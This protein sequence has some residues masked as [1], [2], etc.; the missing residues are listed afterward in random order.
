VI[1]AVRILSRVRVTIDGFLDWMTGFIDTIFT[2][3][4]ITDIAGDFIFTCIIKF[5]S[6]SGGKL[7][8]LKKYLIFTVRSVKIMW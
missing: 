8:T 5:K 6:R 1:S 2:H 4:G 7:M 3:L